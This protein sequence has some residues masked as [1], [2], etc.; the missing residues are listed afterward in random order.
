[1]IIGY[2]GNVRQGKTLSAV[3]S[4][5]TFY[6]Q[7]YTI[8]SNIPLSFPHILIDVDFLTNIV[9]IGNPFPPEQKPLLFLDEVHT[10][11]DS[12]SSSSTRSKVITMLILQTGKLGQSSDFGLILLFTSQYPD[13]IDKRLRHTISIAVECE[14]VMLKNG[15]KWFIQHKYFFR[16]SKSFQTNSFFKGTQEIYNLYDTKHVVKLSKD[17]YSK[18]E[19]VVNIET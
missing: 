17:K 18:K 15:D 4:I 19:T 5:Y 10:V 9:E 6:L 16:G 14:K 8:Y 11:L 12:R 7:G 13:Q 1:M 2:F 3:K